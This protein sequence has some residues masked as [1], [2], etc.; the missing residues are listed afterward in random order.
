METLK[1]LVNSRI[2]LK[3]LQDDSGRASILRNS[4]FTLGGDS[5]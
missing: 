3:L 2:S 1:A 5:F 4:Y